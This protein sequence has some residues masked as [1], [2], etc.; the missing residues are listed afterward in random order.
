[1]EHLETDLIYRIIH[2]DDRHAFATLIRR[3]QSKIRNFLRRL[4]QHDYA[5]ADDLAQECFI[6]AYYKIK[7]LDLANSFAAWLFQIAYR[8]FL[9]HKR[10]KPQW[11]ALDEK[12]QT[13]EIHSDVLSNSKLEKALKQLPFEQRLVVNLY[14]F[15]EFTQLEITKI[16][17]LP[18]GTVKSHLK[19]AAEKLKTI[20]GGINP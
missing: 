4:T 7:Q 20:L 2:D 3:Y 5:L 19:R 12:T 13:D 6:T 17:Q 16:T 1:M 14:Y 9:Q 8:T 18:M 10:Q 15:S 11:E